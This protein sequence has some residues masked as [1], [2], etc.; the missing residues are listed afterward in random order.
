MNFRPGL[1][2][3]LSG[4]VLCL[5][6]ACYIQKNNIFLDFIRAG[7]AA[8]RSGESSRQGIAIDLFPELCLTGKGVFSVLAVKSGHGQFP[9]FAAGNESPGCN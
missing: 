6:L 1:W 9:G 7:A 5:I 3:I 4:A 8:G 2:F